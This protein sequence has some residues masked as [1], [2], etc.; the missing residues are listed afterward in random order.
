M[1]KDGKVISQL[2]DDEGNLGQEEFEKAMRKQANADGELVGQT[3]LHP[4]IFL[5]VKA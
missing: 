1:D 4:V 5:P 2:C 3:F